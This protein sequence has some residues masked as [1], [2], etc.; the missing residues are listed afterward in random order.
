M[1]FFAGKDL[2]D[3]GIG[4]G[5]VAGDRHMRRTGLVPAI[6]VDDVLVHAQADR[7]P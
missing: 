7:H 2:I 3:F 5:I 1:T 6:L 4:G